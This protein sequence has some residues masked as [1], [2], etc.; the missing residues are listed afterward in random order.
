MRGTRLWQ[1]RQ[2]II[3]A[4]DRFYALYNKLNTND[5]FDVRCRM[6]A[7][8]GTRLKK[9]VCR[10]AFQEEAEA[11]YAQ[12][13]FRG[14]VVPT[15][16]VIW[17]QRSDDYRKNVLAVVNS[18]RRLRDLLRERDGLEKQY[19]AEHSKRFKDRWIVFE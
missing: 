3:E 9:R 16:E 11:E 1:M 15:P 13:L 4:E 12:S 10:V 18:D 19:K 5:D 2:A 7:P 14:G 17:L 8:L 6:E